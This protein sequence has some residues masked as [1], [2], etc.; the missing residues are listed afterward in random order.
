MACGCRNKNKIQI[1]SNNK[2]V[3]KMTK[4]QKMAAL[5]KVIEKQSN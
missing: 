2:K 5:L 3:K 4:A 1:T